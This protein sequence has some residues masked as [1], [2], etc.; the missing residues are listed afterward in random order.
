MLFIVLFCGAV[1]PALNR[2]S[3]LKQGLDRL[4]AKMYKKQQQQQ[5]RTY[6]AHINVT[7]VNN[8]K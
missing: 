6:K 8:E 7:W 3:G 1:V 4:A 5:K 2:I